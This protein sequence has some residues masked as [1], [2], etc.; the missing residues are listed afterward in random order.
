MKLFLF[1]LRISGLWPKLVD[2][3]FHPAMGGKEGIS[4]ILRHNRVSGE[5]RYY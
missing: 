5:K 2:N 1:S 3:I 4:T